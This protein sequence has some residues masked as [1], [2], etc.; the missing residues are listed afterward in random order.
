MQQQMGVGNKMKDGRRLGIKTQKQQ[1][2][3]QA[4]KRK[5]KRTYIYG[6][7]RIIIL[8]RKSFSIITNT[9]QIN[10]NTENFIDH[11]IFKKKQ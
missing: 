5:K 8:F 9:L 10:I 6:I 4:C 1:K 3:V 11:S 2:L 7:I